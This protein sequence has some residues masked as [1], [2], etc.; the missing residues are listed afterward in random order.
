MPRLLAFTLV[1]GI[2]GC[3]QALSPNL[4]AHLDGWAAGPADT[5]PE[6]AQAF[7]AELSPLPTDALLVVYDINGPGGMTGTLEVMLA[8]GAR[9]RENWSLSVWVDGS[10]VEL[11]GST[12]QTADAIAVEGPAGRSVDRVPLGDLARAYLAADAQTQQRAV[13]SL[14]ALHARL[15]APDEGTRE[16]ILGVACRPMRVASQDL[17]MWDA[18][19][20]PLRYQGDAFELRAVRIDLDPQLGEHA[21]SIE[22]ALPPATEGWD[23]AAALRA[24][25]AGSYGELG[26][27]LHPG[28]RLPTG[29]VS[30]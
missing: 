13:A 6:T 9:R 27:W 20:L 30:A 8:A 3:D 23:A 7:V 14:R 12:V 5:T 1:L 25:A 10:P 18:T 11:T 17:C 21:F 28:L 22:E 15:G 29:D 16:E 26:P 4:P 19:G 24:L 2:G